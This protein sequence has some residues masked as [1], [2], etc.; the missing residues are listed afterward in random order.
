MTSTA[1]PAPDASA[2]WMAQRT[3]GEHGAQ[4]DGYCAAA[5]LDH[6]GQAWASLRHRLRE[7]PHDRPG[8]AGSVARGS[9]EAS[10]LPCL[11][12]G[13]PAECPFRFLHQ[14]GA[15]RGRSASDGA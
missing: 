8:L 15:L 12:D 14:G 9:L 10:L 2:C 7:G 5:P 11:I 4:I 13:E 6:G 3:L 1:M